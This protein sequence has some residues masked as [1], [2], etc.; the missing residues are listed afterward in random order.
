MALKG[1]K[2]LGGEEGSEKT[3]DRARQAKKREDPDVQD[4]ENAQK[5]VRRAENGEYRDAL[6]VRDVNRKRTARNE[7]RDRQRRSLEGLRQR[8][9]Y[10]FRSLEGHREGIR[11]HERSRW[12]TCMVSLSSDSHLS[13]Y[14]D[15]EVQR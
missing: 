14:S 12:A 6:H 13:E 11:R 5:R 7:K 10:D 8:G 2:K 15:S 1:T 3:R 9:A 4:K